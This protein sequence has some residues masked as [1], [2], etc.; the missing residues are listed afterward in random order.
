MKAFINS[1]GLI[2]DIAGALVFA[3]GLLPSSENIEKFSGGVTYGG[4]VD[5]LKNLLIQNKKEAWIGVILIVLGFILQL[6][7][8]FF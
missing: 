3:K 7:S 6:I 4:K 2:L 8:Q 1:L 5:G